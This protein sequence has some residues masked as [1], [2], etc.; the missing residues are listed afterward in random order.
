M[1]SLVDQFFS[2]CL[3]GTPYPPSG[4][5]YNNP[6]SGNMKRTLEEEIK[7]IYLYPRFFRMDSAHSQS[8]VFHWLAISDGRN[9]SNYCCHA[10]FYSHALRTCSDASCRDREGCVNYWLGTTCRKLHRSTALVCVYPK[11]GNIPSPSQRTSVT[12]EYP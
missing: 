8:T 5:L 1:P 2:Q 10:L 4:L 12:G 9:W 6:K 11:N 7:V 3:V